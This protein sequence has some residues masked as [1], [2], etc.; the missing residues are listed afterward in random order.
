MSSTLTEQIDLPSHPVSGVWVTLSDES[1]INLLGLDVRSLME[2]QWQEERAFARRLLDSPKGSDERGR[3][4]AHAYDTVTTILARIVDPVSG[5]LEMGF[6]RRYARLVQDLLAARQRRNP[7]RVARLFEIGY[8]CG[9]MLDTVHRAGYDAAGIEVSAA[10]REQAMSRLP[11]DCHDR[12]HLGSLLEFQLEQGDPGFDVIFWND[13]LEHLVPD[14]TNDFLRQAHRLLAPGGCLVTITPN[15]HMRPADVTA[16]FCP[17]RTEAVGL[18]LKEY[19]LGEVTSMLHRAGFARVATP[20][21][22][23]RQR[24]YLAGNG[25]AGAKRCFEPML[26][27]LPFKPAKLLIRGLALSCTIAWKAS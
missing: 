23:T 20:L 8:G 21:F 24:M 16:D 18:H 2:L 12:L 7:G 25:L 14:E 26:E 15:W 10:M 9:A 22:V 3:L 27:F 4:F 5:K 17:P 13:V 19:K 1:T 6:D 11:T